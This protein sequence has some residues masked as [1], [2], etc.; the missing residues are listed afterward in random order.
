MDDKKDGV[1]LNPKVCFTVDDYRR[2]EEE[3]FESVTT[4]VVSEKWQR[5]HK[6]V[7]ERFKRQLS[8]GKD[9]KFV[10][11]ERACRVPGKRS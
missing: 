4:I 7:L 3:I 1:N 6:S 11:G 10:S 8:G 5:K 2:F 9:L